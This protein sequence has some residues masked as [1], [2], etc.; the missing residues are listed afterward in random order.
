MKKIFENTL[1]KDLII[2]FSTYKENN[3]ILKS[4]NYKLKGYNSFCGDTFT[5]YVK[6]NKKKI[7]NITFTGAGCIISTASSA[8]MTMCLKNKNVGEFFTIYNNLKLS[9]LK[10]KYI[11]FPY[12]ELQILTEVKNLPSRIK[13][14]T[15]AWDILNILLKKYK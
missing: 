1:Y 11:K 14:T 7:K 3:F 12:K 13:C 6:L 4:A 15:L 8:I 10:K 9:L 2:N 5:I